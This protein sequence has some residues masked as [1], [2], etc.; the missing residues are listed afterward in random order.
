MLLYVVYKRF[1]RH[2]SAP[3]AKLLH[4]LLRPSEY[5]QW[6]RLGVEDKAIEWHRVFVQ[7]KQIGVFKGFCEEE[8]GRTKS[9]RRSTY[10]GIAE[11]TLPCLCRSASGS[12]WPTQKPD[13]R[14]RSRSWSTFPRPRTF[15]IHV[16]AIC[17]PQS[18]ARGCTSL[19]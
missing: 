10:I 11:H 14:N 4:L 6:V 5:R 19:R 16:G 9:D 8:A 7:A 12:P 1:G 17:H 13:W 3:D 15:P 2:P 18:S